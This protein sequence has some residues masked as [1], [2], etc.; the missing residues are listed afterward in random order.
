METVRDNVL[1]I[2]GN[3][4]EELRKRIIARHEAAGQV[5][6]GRTRD[7]LRMEITEGRGVL[8]GRQAFG[9]LEIGR[10]SGKVPKGFYK[11]IEQWMED[12]GIK[13]E[14]PKSF[15]YLVARKIANEGTLLYRSGQSEDIYS[16]EVEKT[17][18]DI[19][20][21]LVGIFDMEVEH[22]NLNFNDENRDI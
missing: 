18:E 19:M 12:K 4:L 9:V 21:R 13:V 10:K 1:R 8:L 7:S 2:V 14:R 5:A 6:S 3:E 22:I 17:I 20:E 11:I 15:S 16:S